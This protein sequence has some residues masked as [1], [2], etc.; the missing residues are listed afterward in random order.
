M[1]RILIMEDEEQ[2]RF[3]FR[4]IL[5][6]EGYEVEEAA[7]GKVGTRLLGES[8]Y[9]LVLLDIVMPEQ[10]GLETIATL[11]QEHP[12]MKIVAMSGGGQ[13]GGED[14]LSIAQRL[15]AS[16]TLQKPIYPQDLRETV[17]ELLPLP[18]SEPR[19]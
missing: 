19:E 10:D 17:R 13:I 16:R 2:I 5:E 12:A 8:E 3:V 11:R 15:G 6:G 9:D 18:G 14:Y 1:T 7:D 4:R